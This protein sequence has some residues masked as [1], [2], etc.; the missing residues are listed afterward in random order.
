MP[1]PK[2]R[3]VRKSQRSDSSPERSPSPPP[4]ALT[5]LR[6]DR[7][8]SSQGEQDH[9]RDTSSATREHRLTPGRVALESDDDAEDR[10]EEE[11]GNA[12][13]REEQEEVS[14]GDDDPEN[15]QGTSHAMTHIFFTTAFLS[16]VPNRRYNTRPSTQ[17]LHPAVTLGLAPRRRQDI[18]AA[19]A[20]KKAEKEAEKVQRERVKSLAAERVAGGII[21]IARM[22][23]ERRLVDLRKAANS[24]R[25]PS[26]IPVSSTRPQRPLP[27]PSGPLP[28][29]GAGRTQEIRRR[30]RGGPPGIPASIF[31]REHTARMALS[32]HCTC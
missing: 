19:A 5:R 8:P 3:P 6:R 17:T 9:D 4:R 28:T 31:D 26:G 2:P 27:E 15:S 29:M 10:A 18:Q 20:Q 14:E 30:K 23:E 21:N 32:P 1:P 16:T 12:A 25:P 11:D 24:R 22:Q 7:D 13:N